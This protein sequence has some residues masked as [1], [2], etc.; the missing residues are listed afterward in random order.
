MQPLD[1]QRS[2]S[3]NFEPLWFRAVRFIAFCSV[4]GILVPWYLAILREPALTKSDLLIPLYFAPLWAP[5]VWIFLRVNSQAED[6]TRKKALALAIGWGILA[7]V[8][9]SAVSLF[10]LSS[11][12]FR[13]DESTAEVVFGG[14]AL[15]QFSLIIA[16]TKAYYSMKPGAGDLRV[17]LWRLGIAGC[18]LLTFLLAT[19]FLHL[20]KSVPNEASAVA[21]LRSINT[22]QS[23]YARVHPD[24]GFAVS[25]QDLGPSPGADLIDG[26]LASGKRSGYIITMFAAP[27]D[28]HGRITRYTI[29]AQP[30]RF[31]KDGMRSFLT[32]ESG[33]LHL[34]PE[35]RTPTI[36]DPVL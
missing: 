18:I 21:S 31:A 36:Q 33:A 7:F 30:R 10:M 27:P 8:L 14:L 35:N 11:V 19:P 13:S 3:T 20:E 32:D 12:G 2:E 26:V 9:F 23:E 24:K 34:T 25:L 22:A 17:L 5:Y 29:V 1:S 28:S 6:L 4:F 16:S 15:L